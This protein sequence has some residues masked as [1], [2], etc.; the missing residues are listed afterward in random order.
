MIVHGRELDAL[1]QH[2]IRTFAAAAARAALR[3]AA[4]FVLGQRE[5]SEK[6]LR[7]SKRIKTIQDD[8]AATL[9]AAG[10]EPLR[11]CTRK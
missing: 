4:F 10:T 5:T 9:G 11:P 3:S 7:V 2:M 1:A 6:W 8:Q